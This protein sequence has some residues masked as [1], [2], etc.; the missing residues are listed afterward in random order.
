VLVNG[1]H[2]PQRCLFSLPNAWK[3]KGVKSRVCGGQETCF[4]QRVS[5][6]D[7]NNGVSSVLSSII[8]PQQLT[9]GKQERLYHSSS[10]QESRQGYA[11]AAHLRK[12]GKAMPQQLT[13]GKPIMPQQLTSGKAMPQQLTS[14][15]Q[16]R[17]CHSSSPQESRQGYYATAAHLRKAGKAIMPQQLTS[18][19]QERLCHSSSPQESRKG[20]ATAAHLRKAVKAMPQ[21]LTSGKQERLYHSSSPQESRKRYATAAHLRKAGKALRHE[22]AP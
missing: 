18:G 17:L 1:N 6:L 14:G 4:Q 8:M 20:Y 12:A 22:I 15:K 9:S 19:K 2:R 7:S 10:P 11:A 21:Q 16:E 13:S 5:R 3:T